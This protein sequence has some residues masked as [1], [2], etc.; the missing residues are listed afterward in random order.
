M[1]KL[2]NEL[3][4]LKNEYNPQKYTTDADIVFGIDKAIIAVRA[5]NPWHEVTELPPS[6]ENDTSASV[7]VYARGEYGMRGEAFYDF[8]L[9]EW[10]WFYDTPPTHWAYLPEVKP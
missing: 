3:E 2:L 1:K 9:C 8:Y 6:K 5:H 7:D 10:I 4:A